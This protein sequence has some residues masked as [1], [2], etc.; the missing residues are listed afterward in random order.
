MASILTFIQ[1]FVSLVLNTVWH[2]QDPVLINVNHVI[3]PSI[4]IL[5]VVNANAMINIFNNQQQGQLVQ[6]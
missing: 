6:K 2:V 5:L 1:V 3:H 4:V